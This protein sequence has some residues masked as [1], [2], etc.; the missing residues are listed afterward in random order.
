M[1]RRYLN[2]AILGCGPTGLMAAHVA[3]IAGHNVT[4]FSIKKKSELYGCQYL[5]APIPFFPEVRSAIVSYTQIGDHENYRRKVYGSNW[6]GTVSTQELEKPHPAWDIRQSY[7]ILW[8][9][10]H[11]IIVDE[12][13]APESLGDDLKKFDVFFSSIPAP[14][15]CISPWEKHSFYSQDI[16]AWGET[17]DRKIPFDDPRILWEIEDNSILCNGVVNPKW[18]R[19]SRVFGYGTV[20]WPGYTDPK[21]L[22]PGNSMVNKPLSTNCNCWPGIHRIGR[23]GRWKK[24]ILTHHAIEEVWKALKQNG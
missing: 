8:D 11:D 3:K 19:M 2:V 12:V 10:Y 4:V 21:N 18:Y 14:S 6:A 16:Y 23:Y 7:D 9:M 22:L 5:H 15:I 24:G 13:I 20:E 17:D 1:A